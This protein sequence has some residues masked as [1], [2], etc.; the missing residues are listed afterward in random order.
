M[1]VTLEVRDVSKSFVS[2]ASSQVDALR[3]VAF[4]VPPGDLLAI[5]GPS[6]CGKTTLLNLIAGLDTPDSGKVAVSPGVGGLRLGYLFQEDRL[7]PWRTT[8]QNVLLG[9][10]VRR[11]LL[12]DD[13]REAQD[14]IQQLGLGG[15]EDAY[16]STLSAGMKRRVA[17]ARTL[18]VEPNLLLLD[19][20]F[21]SVDYESRLAL[22]NLILR[23]VRERKITALVVSHDL[24]QAIVLGKRVLVLTSRPAAVRR[25][26]DIKEPLESREAL[27]FRQRRDFGPWL[28]ELSESMF[29]IQP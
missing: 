11:S 16:P 17:L 6:G 1:S 15:F 14:L 19:E 12:P 26:I 9:V 18:L 28:R 10:E 5:V 4:D 8:I 24:E 22:E 2:S 7:L 23:I 27:E 29:Q 21:S 3:D 20:P 13:H 25:I